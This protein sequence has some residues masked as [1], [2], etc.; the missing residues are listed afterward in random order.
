MATKGPL[1]DGVRQQL[2]EALARLEELLGRY[3]PAG[4]KERVTEARTLLLDQRA[5]RLVVVG[6]RGSGKSS[7][8]N[9]LFGEKVA[10][11]G[12][13]KA[14]TGKAAW[15]EL[16][17]AR[18]ALDVLDTRGFQEGSAPESADSAT[19]AVSSIR[20]ALR[21]K[22]P[23]AIVFLVRASDVDSAI[24]EDVS[25][26]SRLLREND[27]HHGGKT[28]VLAL[29]T[30]CDQVEP[31]RVR[32]SD[33]SN[34]S[35]EDVAEK[36]A[37][38]ETIERHLERKLR[39]VPELDERLVS[40]LGV[41][42][43]QS[44]RQD[45]SRRADERWRIDDLVAFLFEELPREARLEFAR[46]ARV[47]KFQHDVA[48]TLTKTIAGACAAMAAAPIPI[49]DIVSIT[50]AQTTLVLAIGYVSGRHLTM[51]T[52][53]EFLGALGANVGAAFAFREAARALAKCVAPGAGTVVSSTIAYAGTASIGK[54]AAA[55]FIDGVSKEAAK[56]V[57]DGAFTRIRK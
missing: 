16:R 53:A 6:R 11:L 28:A 36:L 22:A 47:R 19:T 14:Q 30:H 50:T 9:A 5:P 29:V 4:M 52:A 35:P 37:R 46:F 7:L 23:D 49:A 48:G 21:A 39:A 24:D 26:L 27:A 32:L 1:E 25:L 10:E 33:P 3:A 31:Q 45:D 15:F 13:E 44:W 20:H 38:I 17:G 40:V 41:T 12:H 8:L 55:Y 54:A 2:S 42:T 43:Y 34:E 18:G 56:R 57:F 51:Q